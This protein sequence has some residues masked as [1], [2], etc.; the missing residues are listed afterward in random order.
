M[1]WKK[2]GLKAGLE[3]HQQLDT[4]HKLFCNCST[5]FS[6]NPLPKEVRRRLRPVVGE[7]GDVDIAALHES[8]R[9]KEFVYKTYPSESCL[10]ETDSEPPHPL[11]PEAIEIAVEVAVLLNCEIPDEIHVMRK[12]VIDGSNPSGFQR[13]AIVGM[14]GWVETSFGRVGIMSVTLEEESAQILKKE[15]GRTLFGL[16]RL[17]IP[18]VEISTAP[19]IHTPEQGREL[20]EK[21]GMILRSSRVKRGLGTIRQDLNISIQGGARTESKGVQNLRGIKKLIENEALRQQKLIEKGKKVKQEVRKTNPDGST[22]FLRPLPGAARLYPE[23]DCLPIQIDSPFLSRIKKNLPELLEDKRQKL[24]KELGI[25]HSM[26]KALEKNKELELFKKLSQF[27]NIHP[28]FAA[29]ILL[30]YPYD[31]RKK[32]RSADP[33]LVDAN[34]II[35]VFEKLNKGEISKDSVLDLLAD[36]SLGKKLDFGE[37]KLE[38]IDIETEVKKVLKE[39][40]GLSFGAY[41]GIL[42]G[43]YKGKVTGE[44]IA[45][46]LKK[47]LK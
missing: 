19:D 38:D 35:A 29:K 37:Y 2:I 43:K 40:P 5:E 41:M 25:D 47:A 42:M 11:N 33:F 7:T 26:V 21:L 28:P 34:D 24:T 15:K 13:T 3:I 4:K 17:G 39:K 23:T 18:L 44:E 31:I 14:D 45:K 27:K 22:S 20:A 16:N 9:G 12:T 8:L 30:S 10:I 6:E 36:I 46:A 32:H 1:D